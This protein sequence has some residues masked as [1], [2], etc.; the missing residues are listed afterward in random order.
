M[1]GLLQLS[2]SD[3]FKGV[4][5][6]I[7][8]VG[9]TWLVQFYKIDFSWIPLEWKAGLI[10]FVGYLIKGLSTTDKG[11]VLGIAGGK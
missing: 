9:L 3:I 10:T 7:I 8:V 11:N 1:N 6:A 2:W 4:V 5:T